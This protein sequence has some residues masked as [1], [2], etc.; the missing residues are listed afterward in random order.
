MFRLYHNCDEI[1]DDIDIYIES[2]SNSVL[3]CNMPYKIVMN[4]ITFDEINYCPFCGQKL[5]VP[6]EIP[7]DINVFVGFDNLNP[8][9]LT[10][11]I[12]LYNCHNIDKDYIISTAEDLILENGYISIKYNENN[13]ILK[14][15]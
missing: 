3:S 2:K 1:P 13:S 12:P 7:I 11:N 14:F 6:D 9:K 15:I 10:I 5:E 8:I 4:N